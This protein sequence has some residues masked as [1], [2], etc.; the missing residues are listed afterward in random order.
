MAGGFFDFLDKKEA[1]HGSEQEKGLNN[2]RE[3]LKKQDT[4]LKYLH[5]YSKDLHKYT[6]YIN[7]SNTRHKTEIVSELNKINQWVS[8]LHESNKSLKQEIS[9]LKTEMRKL[10]KNDFEVY[11]KTLE[12]Y[13]KLKFEEEHAKKE[14]LRSSIL[15][16][17]K[18]NRRINN[19]DNAKPI[20]SIMPY[21]AEYELTNPE[22]ALLNLL[23]NENKPMTYEAM[24][25][26]LNKS[27]NSVR[28]YMNSLR[29]KKQIIDEFLT[30]NGSKVFSI[31]NSELVKTL[32]N[33]K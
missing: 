33:I 32:F 21:N 5:N 28:V 11:H 7:D 9:A 6:S 25:K 18:E 3:E 20:S 4:W 2:I 29:A 24:S 17:L 16:E 12:Q 15:A 22:K 14:E 23:F 13:L 26:K 8:Y 1:M 10:L 30:P 19:E 27:V 31:K